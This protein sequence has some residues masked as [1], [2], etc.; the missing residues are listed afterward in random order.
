M[1]G[2]MGHL[3]FS[4]LCTAW[5]DETFSEAEVCSF[6]YCR[7]FQLCR[8]NCWFSLV[9]LASLLLFFIHL[10]DSTCIHVERLELNCFAHS[11]IWVVFK[12][13]W[14]RTHFTMQC[15]NTVWFILSE[16]WVYHCRCVFFSFMNHIIVLQNPLYFDVFITLR[17]VMWLCFA[18]ISHCAGSVG[19]WFVIP[20]GNSER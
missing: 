14:I 8:V 20:H 9:Q 7:H 16:S 13:Y 10:Y 12:Y 4:W 5:K 15:K 18:T 17:E 6:R 2:V 19:K 1:F 11:L 3:Y